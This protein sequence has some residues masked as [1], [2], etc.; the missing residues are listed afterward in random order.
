MKL[1]RF[2]IA[3]LFWFLLASIAGAQDAVPSRHLV[4]DWS[5]RHVVFTGLTPEN[6]MAI[7]DADPRA[8]HVWVHHSRH[9]FEA[10]EA[11]GSD[12][13]SESGAG[14]RLFP[15]HRRHRHPKGLKRDWEMPVDSIVGPN[16][17]PAKFS[18]DVNAAPDC[19]NDYVV[20]PTVG[21]GDTPG[22]GGAGVRASLMAFNNLYAG[23]GP[24]GICPTP[25]S[26]ATQPSVLFA[27]NTA[28]MSS[29]AVYLSPTLSLDGKKIAFI[30]SN[31]GSG[32][33]YTAF[34]VLTWKAGE[35]TA[36]NDA[37]APGNC[38]AGN[39]CMAT[40]VLSFSWS[41][42]RSNPFI[43][44]AHD[45]AYVGD[46]G[47]L[48]HKIT[49]VFSGTPA[50]V[51]GSGWPVQ[52]HSAPRLIESPVYDSV[53]GRI[54]VADD[55]GTLYI[56]DPASGGLLGTNSPTRF[57]TSDPIVDS[58]NQTVFLFGPDSNLNFSVWQLDTSGTLLQ[59]IT[60]GPH[61][62][63]INAYIGAFD[64]NYYS[65][66]SSGLLYCAGS[67]SGGASLFAIGFT[68]TTMNSSFSG[69]LVLVTSTLTSAP[70]PLTEVF[71]PSFSTA[72]DRL[73]LGID[74]NCAN[75]SPSG[76][77][78]SFDISNGFPS[79]ILNSFVLG[80]PGAGGDVSGIV[81][82][83]VSSAPQAS[84]I[85]F[86]SLVPGSFAIKLTQSSLQ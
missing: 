29:G 14:E 68:G 18:F 38:S 77:I 62:G 25:L 3:P 47:G 33:N 15:I 61:G 50:E 45:T 69:P 24:S 55:F 54:F 32:N 73:F 36:W 52:L 83:N 10:A 48:L 75:G 79:G 1:Y 35:G 30:E 19:T 78:E 65:N 80:T 74:A 37:A 46:D 63:T 66:P 7:A 82:D 57:P 85:Y 4:H 12:L 8:W 81:V 56:L 17:F 76:C 27:Y 2:S 40:L 23:P 44:Y 5:N 28:T 26:P 71:N 84:S 34:H 60:A 53:S 43:D 64:N 13:G 49:P 22:L 86:E 72:K 42:S 9:R 41:D 16:V 21:F 67:L 31:N 39:S 59:T 58:S 20:F 6:V 11:P 70:T 51:T